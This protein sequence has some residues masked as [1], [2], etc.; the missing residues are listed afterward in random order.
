MVPV[1]AVLLLST[2]VFAVPG[3]AALAQGDLSDLVTVEMRAGFDGYFRSN[4]WLPVRVEVTNNGDDLDGVIVVRPETSGSAITNT[5][6]APVSLP[7]GSRQ[8]LFLYVSARGNAPR[9]RVELLNADGGVVADTEAPLRS[10]TAR[11]RLY[12]VV[13]GAAAGTTIDLEPVTSGGHRALQANWRITDLPDRALALSAVDALVFND[14]DTG[15]LMPGQRDALRE[16]VTLGGQLIA[17]GG[18]AW[19]PTAAGLRDL[20]P[21]VPDDSQTLADLSAL[22][23]FGG[24]YVTALTGDTLLAT[25]T[26]AED[27]RVLA[28]TDDGLPLVARRTLGSGTVDYLAVDP[29]SAPLR[30]WAA[31]EGL[32]LTLLTSPDSTPSWANGFKNFSE[33]KTAVEILP[34]LDLLPAA[35]GLLAFLAAYVGLVGP[36]NYLILSRLNRREWAWVTIPVLILVFSLLARVAGFNL[37][38]NQIT[39]SRLTVIQA[40]PDTDEAHIE[41]VTGLLAPRRD[42]YALAVTEER[43][44]RSLPA[45]VLNNPLPGLGS[46]RT[47]IR[48]T[49]TFA[50]VDFLVDASFIAAFNASGIV[51]RPDISG[52]AVLTY[53]PNTVSVALRGAVSNRTDEPLLY[54]V[55]LA[56]SVAYDLGE[57]LAPG[58]VREFADIFLSG[59]EVPQPSRIEAARGEDTL[60]SSGLGYYYGGTISA[61]FDND[62][63]SVGD[64][65]GQAW[66]DSDIFAVVDDRTDEERRRQ[67]FLQAFV[68]DQYGSTAR[69][70]RV[71]LAAW[72]AGEPAADEVAGA[73]WSALDTTLYLIELAVEIDTTANRDILITRDQFTWTARER[74]TNDLQASP[75]QLT[76]TGENEAVF[77]FTPLPGAVLGT[78]DVLTLLVERMPGTQ[79]SSDLALWNW[80]EQTW[81]P[82]PFG[83][84]ERLDIRN[85]ERYLGPNNAVEVR[86]GR[87]FV[88]ARVDINLLAVEQRGRF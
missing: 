69:G 73:D 28:A 66:I 86:V 58:E 72:G 12:V 55:L 88:G 5:F 84:T 74:G 41:Q 81:E 70:N 78:V 15:T 29:N 17:T 19:Q 67:A 43:M 37:R 27:A 50:A 48:Q 32:W 2:R 71:F 80:R 40:W 82:A 60:F 11:D 22:V 54:P 61:F 51:P 31:R 53:S 20:L 64:I 14:V 83:D 38:G 85:P 7:N 23:Q 77:R 79:N 21:L 33:A 68:R 87:S 26:L 10:I 6:T 24:D 42:T 34:G 18:A 62:Y 36:V 30:G 57:S 9:L 46:G 1:L 44:L 75:F 25:G 4:A 47:E 45:D 63:R 13:S 35:L 16:W 8:T 76:L 65:L 39:L 56:R 49:D 52:Q 3:G 59:S